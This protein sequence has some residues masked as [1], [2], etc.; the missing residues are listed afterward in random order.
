MLL[1]PVRA[2]SWR[3]TWDYVKHQV[4]AAVRMDGQNEPHRAL[5]LI[6][7]DRADAPDDCR[8]ITDA[9]TSGG[10]SYASLVYTKGEEHVEHVDGY[11][12]GKEPPSHAVFSGEISNKLPENNP[13]IERTGFAAW[14]TRESGSSILGNHVWNVDPYTHLALRIKSDGRKYFVNIKSESIVPT[15]LHQHLLRAFRPGTWETVYI[16]FS[17]FARTN[18]GFIVEPQREMLRQKVTSVGIGLADRIPGPFEICIA[19]IYATNRPWRSR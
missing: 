13:S 11:I 15:D 10:F 5:P 7:F 16:P 3:S 1:S 4:V 9:N 2:Q 14:R 18:Y 8:I 19:D 12:G 17:A 6:Q